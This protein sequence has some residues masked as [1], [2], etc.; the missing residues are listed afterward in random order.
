MLMT[1]KILRNLIY[2]S[3]NLKLRREELVESCN[4]YKNWKFNRIFE[5]II[6]LNFKKQ[7]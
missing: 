6:C 4:T 3:I 2:K 1:F 5:K 7:L